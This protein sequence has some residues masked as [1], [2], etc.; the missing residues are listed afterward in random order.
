MDAYGT[1][2][3]SVLYPA[4]ESVLRGRP[5]LARLDYLERTQWRSA[6]E[7][8]SIQSG[9]LQRLLKHAFA[10]VPFYRQRFEAAG[11]TPSDIRTVEDLQK[12]PLLTRAEASASSEARR[13]SAPP[14]PTIRKSTSGSSGAPLTFAYDE[15]SEYWRQAVKL[16]GYAWAGYKLGDRTLH[17][18]GPPPRG[19]A[20]P[21]RQQLKVAVDRLLRRET[22]LDCTARNEAYMLRVVDTIRR[23]T[24]R[25][26]ICF[27]QSGGELARFINERGLR[28]WGTIPVLCGAEQ[29]YP[30]DRAE[31]ERAFGPAVFETYGAREVML[32]ASECEA[33]DGLHV[34][35]E[36]ILVEIVVTEPDGRT[37]AA[38]PGERGEVVVTDLH[39]F[40]MPFLRY[41]N[42]DLAVAGSAARCACGRLLSRLSSIEGRKTDTLRDGQGGRVSGLVVNTIMVPHAEAIRRF[43]CIQHK[44]LSI[45]LKLVPTPRFHG[46]VEQNVLENMQLRI[47]GVPIRVELVDEVD[48]SATGKR[49]PVV[50]EA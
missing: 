17:Y 10:H 50:V 9:A 27:S 24:P 44:D 29:L 47:P 6:D 33:H 35:M 45:T 21:S 7:L 12:L 22:Y 43:Q 49:R 15:G 23:E 46:R 1:L 16:R 30:Q 14:L 39:N 40:G 20:Q 28:D 41:A 42:G 48:A 5:T 25:A 36:N 18:W 4:Y 3:R 38:R 8:A 32:I 37:R 31:L 11:L 34:A 26:L 19:T 13:S 2:F